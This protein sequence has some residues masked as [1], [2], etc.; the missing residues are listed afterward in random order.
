MFGLIA[1]FFST[2]AAGGAATL[3]IPVITFLLGA[4]MVA[5]IISI[6]ALFANPSRAVI[7]RKN[8]DWQV[9][10]YLLPGSIIG[11]V[12]GSWS[13][14][15]TNTQ[16]IQILLGLFLITYVLQDRFSKVK[17]A[18]KMKLIWFFPL[19]LSVSFLSGLIGATGPV[20]NPFMLN[21]GLEKEHLVGTKAINSLIMQLTKLISYGAFGALSLQIASFGVALGLG[22][23]VGVF[24]ARKQ[25]SRV[26]S[27][28]FRQYTLILMFI[29]GIAMLYKAL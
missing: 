19:G 25:L 23:V 12:M 11:A 24:L 6:A 15:Q 9:I 8:I 7:F 21:Y 3:L 16:I 14:T 27:Q 1:W 18:I 22:A 13:L 20:H 17:L 28:Q 10:R 4:Q 29:S 2:V 26:D 5:P